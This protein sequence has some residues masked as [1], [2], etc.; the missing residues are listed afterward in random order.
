[1]LVVTLYNYLLILLPFNLIYWGWYIHVFVTEKA[2]R[3]R[4][5]GVR[6]SYTLYL[7]AEVLYLRVKWLHLPE[8]LRSLA[9]INRNDKPYQDGRLDLEYSGMSLLACGNYC[10]L[11][12]IHVFACVKI[13]TLV[14][15]TFR[16]SALSTGS[17]KSSC[18]RELI[19]RLYGY[20]ELCKCSSRLL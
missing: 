17:I 10:I 11:S 14:F 19:L 3:K 8:D 5:C 12:N 9:W 1:M 20:L 18:S 7:R 6:H 15:N 13:S 4:P 16:F 2:E